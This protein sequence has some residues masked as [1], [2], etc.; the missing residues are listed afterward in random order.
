MYLTV[1]VA[2]A[3]LPRMPS[4]VGELCFLIA[5]GIAAYAAAINVGNRAGFREA[6]GLIRG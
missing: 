4:E 6:V 3:S 5:V 2:R 1:W